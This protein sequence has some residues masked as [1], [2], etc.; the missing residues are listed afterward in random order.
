MTAAARCGRGEHIVESVSSA[1]G[2]DALVQIIYRS[3]SLLRGPRPEISAGVGEIL[4]MAR[5]QN[6]RF[7]VTGVLF[8]DG[9]HFV[10]T[11]EGPSRAIANLYANIL[12]DRRHTEIALLSQAEMGTRCF[13]GWAM[14]YVGGE[15]EPA[16]TISSGFLSDVAA[17]G[18]EAAGA[19]LEAMQYFLRA[20]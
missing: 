1:D 2:E 8:F 11:L 19:I 3:R 7:D 12:R 10:Q 15:E 5:V 6:P 17:G 13:A 20:K 16:F 4:Q 9:L 14:A 18:G